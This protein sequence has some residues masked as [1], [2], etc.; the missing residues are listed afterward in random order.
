MTVSPLLGMSHVAW[1]LVRVADGR[2]TRTVCLDLQWNLSV[3]ATSAGGKVLV[4]VGDAR[5][6]LRTNHTFTVTAWQAETRV[7]K[8][9]VT[10]LWLTV[11]HW[12]MGEGLTPEKAER[13]RFAGG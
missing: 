10:K 2:T 13:S 12:W 11:P 3:T 5:G 8:G 4:V 1:L 9:Q 7:S 6:H